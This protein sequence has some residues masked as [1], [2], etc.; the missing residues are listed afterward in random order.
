MNHDP[1]PQLVARTQKDHP[2]VFCGGGMPGHRS[3]TSGKT[4]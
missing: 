1:V 2:R 4:P 3:P